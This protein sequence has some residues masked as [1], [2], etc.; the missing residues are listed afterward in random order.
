MSVD[1]SQAE[2]LVY[3]NQTGRLTIKDPNLAVTSFASDTTLSLAD[4]LSGPLSALPADE[5]TILDDGSTRT[6]FRSHRWRLN[7]DLTERRAGSAPSQMRL[8]LKT[9][10][11]LEGADWLVQTGWCGF[12]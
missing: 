8:A 4:L 5:N 3:D 7:Y 10:N 1:R 6:F 2:E 9:S 11:Q 12:C